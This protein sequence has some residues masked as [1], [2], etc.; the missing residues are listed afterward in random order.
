M[1]KRASPATTGGATP[2]VRSGRAAPPTIYNSVLAL[3]TNASSVT[4]PAAPAIP[5]PGGAASALGIEGSKGPQDITLRTVLA[6]G[7]NKPTA[8]AFNPHDDSLWV[9]NRGDDSSIKI[10]GAATAN[11]TATKWKDDSNHFMNNPMGIAFSPLYN[12]FASVQDTNNDY[13]GMAPGNN[14][15]GPTLWPA[16]STYNGGHA[17]HLD[18]LHHSPHSVGIAAGREYAANR[19]Y[20]VFNGEKGCVDRY[21]FGEPHVHGGDDH[22]DGITV[23]YATG[24]LTP[25]PGIPGHLALDESGTLF[26]ADTGNGRVVKLDTTKA[27]NGNVSRIYGYHDETPLYRID[28]S[29]QAFTSPSAGLVKPCG[30]AIH[31]DHILVSDHATGHIKSFSKDGALV[32]DLDTGLGPNSITGIAIKENRLYVTDAATNRV[33]EISVN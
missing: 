28:E 18:M 30:V 6:S 9:V 1:G 27:L 8:L 26:I 17:S 24:E 21:F 2:S 5:A 16:D 33:L 4:P 3:R 31:D 19:E 32:G 13:N 25:S 10:Q 14:F 20:F 11:P 29:I 12:E 15:M 22:S 7:L 23:R